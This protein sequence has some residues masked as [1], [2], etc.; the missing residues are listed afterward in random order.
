MHLS[1]IYRKN[2]IPQRSSGGV[3]WFSWRWF[4]NPDLFCRRVRGGGRRFRFDQT[5]WQAL[6]VFLENQILLINLPRA[7]H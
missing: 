6:A 4:T 7:E 2:R 5:Y 1:G 3:G